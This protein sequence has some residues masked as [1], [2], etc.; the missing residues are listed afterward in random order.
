M[1]VQVETSISLL[2][3]HLTVASTPSY[4]GALEKLFRAITR[5]YKDQLTLSELK[6]VNTCFTPG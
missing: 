6:T 3:V 2:P 1:Q 5:V 4:S